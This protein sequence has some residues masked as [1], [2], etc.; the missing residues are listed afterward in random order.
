MNT[1]KHE[2][3]NKFSAKTHLIEN[4][5]G[6]RETQN[7]HKPYKEPQNTCFAVIL[8]VVKQTFHYST[9][10]KSNQFVSS[11]IYYCNNMLF[12]NLFILI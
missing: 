8:V 11:V 1:N 12:Y 10:F 5:I 7:M 2:Y 9:S 4:L 3:I 6:L